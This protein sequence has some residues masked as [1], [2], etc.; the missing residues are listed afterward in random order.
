MRLEF[1]A[2]HPEVIVGLEH[3]YRLARVAAVIGVQREPYGVWHIVG[4][5]VKGLIIE[6][7]SVNRQ[8]AGIGHRRIVGTEGLSPCL[9]VILRSIKQIAYISRLEAEVRDLCLGIGNILGS[10][11]IVGTQDR[12]VGKEEAA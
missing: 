7:F 4:V 1:E 9:S 5:G 8:M 10:I 6:G 3:L 11:L 2:R 12:T